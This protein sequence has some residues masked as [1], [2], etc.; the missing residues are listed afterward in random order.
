MAALLIIAHAPLASALLAAA[1]HTFA[2]RCGCVEALDVSADSSP[3]AVEQLARD[4]LARLAALDPAGRREVLILSDVFGAT[5]CNA[6]QRVADGQTVR[7]VTGT[8]VPMV[9]RTLNYL[10]EPLDQLI[11]R[12]IAGGTQGVMQLTSARPQNQTLHPSHDQDHRHH[13]Q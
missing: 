10:G 8:N 13:Q 5:P 1:R 7:C 12:A 3:D 2:E 6:A 9:W 11:A 4:A